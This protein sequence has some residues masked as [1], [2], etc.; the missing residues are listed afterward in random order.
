M[1]KAGTLAASVRLHG[2]NRAAV[3]LTNFEPVYNRWAPKPLAFDIPDQCGASRLPTF[4]A[5][6]SLALVKN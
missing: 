1:V 2:G 3:R 6:F 5:P 4:Q